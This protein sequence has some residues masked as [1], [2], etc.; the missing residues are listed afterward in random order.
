MS[1]RDDCPLITSWVAPQ[2]MVLISSN[3]N[4]LNTAS[5]RHSARHQARCQGQASIHT[6][7]HG[8][9]SPL[10]CVD[11]RK[12]GK[13]DPLKPFQPKKTVSGEGLA[14]PSQEGENRH[15]NVDAT[16]TKPERG[17]VLSESSTSMKPEQGSVL[18]E[19]SISRDC[20][21]REICLCKARNGMS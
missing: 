2:C 15:E 17:S 10:H 20:P 13:S 14:F 11:R 18:S 16:S 6:C 5:V 19:S 7:M 4:A 3:I 12:K 9:T 1:Y 21:C 8:T